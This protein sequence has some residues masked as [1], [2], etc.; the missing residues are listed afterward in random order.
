MMAL[1]DQFS[2][3]GIHWFEKG[4]T[5]TSAAEYMIKQNIRTNGEFYIAP[6]FNLIKQGRGVFMVNQFL[7]M[8]TPEELQGSLQWIK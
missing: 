7:S 1:V 8:G 2:M 5:F 3:S 6:T 4:S